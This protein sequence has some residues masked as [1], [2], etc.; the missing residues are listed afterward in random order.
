MYIVIDDLIYFL[1][2]AIL[3]L[4]NLHALQIVKNRKTPWFRAQ[5]KTII[6]DRNL[7]YS[8]IAQHSDENQDRFRRLRNKATLVIMRAK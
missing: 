7:T 6:L 1:N 3:S 8:S 4:L 2:K 5:V